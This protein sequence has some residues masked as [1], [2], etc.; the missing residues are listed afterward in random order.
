M[1]RSTALAHHH[2]W[3]VVSVSYE[4]AF[5]VRELTCTCG[6]TSFAAS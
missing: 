1:G 4:D 5:E 6:E 2:D 3:Q